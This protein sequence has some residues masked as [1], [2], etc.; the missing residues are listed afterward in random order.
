MPAAN[1]PEHVKVSFE[2]LQAN[3]KRSLKICSSGD[4][5]SLRILPEQNLMRRVNIKP[6]TNPDSIAALFGP[7]NFS[8][9]PSKGHVL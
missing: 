3:R 4:I 9:Y 6:A 1:R 7:H 5:K 2:R 8:S